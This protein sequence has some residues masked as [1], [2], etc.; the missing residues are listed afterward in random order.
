MAESKPLNLKRI[1]PAEENMKISH[2]IIAI[3]LLISSR[4]HADV[5]EG[6]IVSSVTGEPVPYVNISISGTGQGTISNPD[7]YFLVKTDTLPLQVE[8]GHIQFKNRILKLKDPFTRI[9][10]EP[11]V[12]QTE[13]IRVIASRAVKGKTPVAFSTIDQKDIQ[14]AYSHQDVPM[15]MKKT[16]GVYVY[17]DAGNGTGYSYL[18]IRGFSQDRIGI[19]LNGIPLNDPESH[20]VYWVDHGDILASVSNIQIQRGTGTY[21]NGATVFGGTVN[22]ETNYAH[23]PRGI[24]ISTGYGNYMG[25]GGLDLPG[26]KISSTYN[27][28]PFA[29]KPLYFYARGSYMDNP[30]YRV[31]SG[32]T[33]KSFHTGFQKQSPDRMTRVEWIFGDE[34][35]HF[36]W[37]GISPQYGYDLNNRDDRRYNFYADPAY[38]GGFDDANK[39][40]FTQHI[41]SLQHSRKFTSSLLNLT[42][43]AVKG[44]GYYEQFKGSQSVK[45]YH[46]TSLLPDTA[47]VDLIRQKWLKN[48]YQGVLLQ[49]N[50]QHINNMDMTLGTEARF[51]Q[52][53]HFGTVT[54]LE[55]VPLSPPDDHKYYYSDSYKNSVSFYLHTVYTLSKNLSI[56]T[57][58][59]FLSHF[60]TFDQDQMGA[61]KGYEYTLKYLFLDPRLG[62]MWEAAD[63]LTL[64][65]NI[66]TAHREPADSDIYDQSDPDAE[67]AIRWTDSKYAEP[68]VKEERLIHTELGIDY[69]TDRLSGALNLYRMDFRNELIPMDYRYRDDDNILKGNVPKTIHQGIETDIAFRF[70]R[71]VSLR[72]NV[73]YSHNSFVE[74]F[75]DALGWGGYGSIADYSGK[76]IPGYP[77]LMANLSGT[78]SLG[79][80]SLNLDIQYT[81]KQYIDFSNTKDAAVSPHTIVNM[82]LNLPFIQSRAGNLTMDVKIY[83]VFD[84]LYETFGYN[85]YLDPD[86]R[87]DVY[88]PAATRNFFLTATW[89]IKTGL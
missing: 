20:S 19:M 21:L 38:N 8:I 84:T 44:D 32:T 12:L 42:L 48:D 75:G 31:G 17:S 43:Y 49:Y 9:I 11:D 10:L 26:Y 28:R 73:S 56:L 80:Y 63:G 2:L 57:D 4:V 5:L 85:Y 41:V 6:L 46:L 88:W 79:G 30:G 77:S 69:S 64:F 18:K 82:A 72:S 65:A 74:F 45:E 76:T 71:H 83:N 15:V 68:L 50:L 29:D 53:D 7:G 60:Y 1:I 3:S 59:R 47:S 22:M 27:G 16:P 62:I 89:H 34:I 51:Y 81:G 35:T 61:F 13:E 86:T 78:F 52:S 25:S 55:N 40:V 39:D 54:S 87:I 66:S 70:N 24:Q 36:S 58:V 33:Q 23:L 14:T 67:P 37:D